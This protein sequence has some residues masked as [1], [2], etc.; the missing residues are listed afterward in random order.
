MYTIEMDDERIPDRTVIK[1]R[2]DPEPQNRTNL[3][4]RLLLATNAVK[5]IIGL[6]ITFIILAIPISMLVI[7]VCY[8]HRRYC[9]IEPRLSVFLIVFG[10][11]GLAYLVLSFILSLIIMFANYTKSKGTFTSVIVL[12]L[13]TLL[14]QLFLIAWIIVGCV[15]TFSIYNTVQYTDRHY[16]WRIYCNGILYFFTFV[17][18]IVI[19][20]LWFIQLLVRIILAI[21]YSRKEE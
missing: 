2:D 3:P 19:M 18:L 13:F 8:H 9:P 6:I 20:V 11:V 5:S 12:A 17:Y 7:G 4:L 21:I 14:I 15:W 1:L 16:Y 10:S